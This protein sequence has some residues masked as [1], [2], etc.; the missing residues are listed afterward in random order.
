[1]RVKR[2]SIVCS[3]LLS[4]ALLFSAPVSAVTTYVP[5]HVILINGAPPSTSL[6]T[7]IGFATI[8][9]YYISDRLSAGVDVFNAKD[10]F[11][12]GTFGAGQ[13][14]G[15]GTGTP[16]RGP[17][18]V[19]VDNNNQIWAGEAIR[20]VKVGTLATGIT[21][22]IPTGGTARADELGLRPGGSSGG[23]GQ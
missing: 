2:I 17:N 1:M 15:A 18:G 14:T 10:D 23:S 16:T 22:T 5:Q 11:F 8:D 7:D 13:F 4:T 19:L 20:T 12:L 9:S 21:H 3:L 6:T